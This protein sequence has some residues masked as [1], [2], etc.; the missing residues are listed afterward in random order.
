MRYLVA[1]PE[2]FV[3]NFEFD[4][5]LPTPMSFLFKKDRISLEVDDSTMVIARCRA[6]GWVA[7]TPP[8][9]LRVWMGIGF[10]LIAVLGLLVWPEIR[11]AELCTR[12][13]VAEQDIA[14]YRAAVLAYYAQ[15]GSVPMD[16]EVQ[17][18]QGTPQP[19]SR[20]SRAGEPPIFVFAKKSFG[21]R[22]VDAKRF[23]ELTFPLGGHRVKRG[24]VQSKQA[25]DQESTTKIFALPME[26]LR[27]RFHRRNLFP[28]NK[29][30]RVAVLWVGGLYLQEALGLQKIVGILSQDKNQPIQSDCFFAPTDDGKTYDAWIYLQDL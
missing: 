29:S 16:V 5:V 27:N 19:N 26:Y 1:K 11:R 24:S 18:D 28:S 17:V 10:L 13:S 9:S 8:G 15:G 23:E 4:L 20:G 14:A 3:K 21:D 2:S 30:D 6:R 25:M 7:A 22:L 12:L